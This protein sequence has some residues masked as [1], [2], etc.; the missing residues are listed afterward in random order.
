MPPYWPRSS[1][2]IQ[3][4][5]SGSDRQQVYGGEV[6]STQSSNAF[7]N[8][9]PTTSA[10]GASRG[11]KEKHQGRIVSHNQR[12]SESQRY[13][14][15]EP[16]H[17]AK[18]AHA[19]TA[20]AS[21]GPTQPVLNVDVPVGSSGGL[22]RRNG[23]NMLA[24]NV[25]SGREWNWRRVQQFFG[26]P[27]QSDKTNSQVFAFK[28][29]GSIRQIHA[30]APRS[31]SQSKA[32]PAIVAVDQTSSSIHEKQMSEQQQN[33]RPQEPLNSAGSGRQKVRADIADIPNLAV[34]PTTEFIP[35]TVP[36]RA[37]SPSPSDFSQSSTR[38]TLFPKTPLVSRRRS[39]TLP[40]P[41]SD[42]KTFTASMADKKDVSG[43]HDHPCSSSQFRQGQPTRVNEAKSSNI[44][45]TGSGEGVKNERQALRQTKS[46]QNLQ[47]LVVR[48]A[49]NDLSPQTKPKLEWTSSTGPHRAGRHSPRKVS[50]SRSID[51]TTAI[52]DK[53]TFTLSAISESTSHNRQAWTTDREDVRA[54]HTIP[55]VQVRRRNS[56]LTHRDKGKSVA[57]DTRPTKIEQSLSGS[58][59]VE[60]LQSRA[61]KQSNKDLDRVQIPH[62]TTSVPSLAESS[63]PRCTVPLSRYAPSH[64]SVDLSNMLSFLPSQHQRSNTEPVRRL[65]SSRALFL[66]SLS[67]PTRL[68]PSVSFSTATPPAPVPKNESVDELPA[69]IARKISV[70]RKPSVTKVKIKSPRL[71]DQHSVKNK[72]EDEYEHEQRHGRRCN[73]K[74]KQKQKT[75]TSST[76]T[77]ADEPITPGPSDSTPNYHTRALPPTPKPTPTLPL[78]SSTILGA[79]QILPRK[80]TL[81]SG[82]GNHKPGSS[83]H[84]LS[85]LD[86]VD[87][88]TER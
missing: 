13:V 25:H 66:E 80:P 65:P 22:D 88:E 7:T 36:R 63:R 19:E 32:T 85:P 79:G 26:R 21:S 39:A 59:P 81:R 38:Y 71:G 31:T 24:M 15:A 70:S 61:E 77:L 1:I 2:R 40:A 45:S 76:E 53:L 18:I 30:F 56:S 41:T 55:S 35:P 20:V 5:Q 68:K 46:A 16:S 54:P 42:T 78:V 50:N 73:Q 33:T 37:T 87:S 67:S 57:D 11:R 74:Q 27:T 62:S 8:E 44:R 12:G 82:D 49:V 84:L 4:D 28:T 10:G 64:T 58:S 29:S 72:A 6:A 3:R 48:H 75:P 86:V 9:R 43:D 60:D 23:Q 47:P 69:S 14:P 51:R 17:F 83:I 34:G 52:V